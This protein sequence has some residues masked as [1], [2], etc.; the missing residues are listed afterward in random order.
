M[1]NLSM[2]YQS[3]LPVKECIQKISA[4]PWEYK[5]NSGDALWYKCEMVSDTRLLVVFTGGQYRKAMRSQ[6]FIDF[7]VEEG[8]TIVTM[9]F[10]KDLFGLPLMTPMNDIDCFMKQKINAIRNL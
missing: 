3:E 6:F 8:N 10:I 5:S 7:M 4:Q 9:C 2:T 1:K